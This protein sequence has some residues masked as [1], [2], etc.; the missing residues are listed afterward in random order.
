MLAGPGR[1]PEVVLQDHGGGL[2]VVLGGQLLALLGIHDRLRVGLAS[3]AKELEQLA[4]P[5]LQ[6][7][8]ALGKGGC[9]ALRRALLRG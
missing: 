8:E 4:G 6:D 5:S 2:C 9:A 3:R 7:S 1:R